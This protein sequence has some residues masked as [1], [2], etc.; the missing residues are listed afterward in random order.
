MRM[1]VQEIQL[2]PGSK[3][4][5][6]VP[7]PQK[8]TFHR[9]VGWGNRWLPRSQ[10]LFGG[11]ASGKTTLG[12]HLQTLGCKCFQQ[13]LVLSLLLCFAPVPLAL[14][15]VIL[16]HWIHYID[17]LLLAWLRRFIGFLLFAQVPVARLRSCLLW[18]PGTASDAF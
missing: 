18:R 13:C 5:C 3:L 6:C 14:P 2:Q 7:G 11:P 17:L 4:P 15:V 12:R 9:F 1:S 16:Y 8:S 10:V